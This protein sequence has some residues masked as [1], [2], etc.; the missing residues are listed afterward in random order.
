MEVRLSAMKEILHTQETELSKVGL[1]VVGYFT[2]RQ[3][4]SV[5]Q[6]MDMLRQV[7]MLPH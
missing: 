6:G 7:H 4:A 2:S 3:H 5:S 1:F